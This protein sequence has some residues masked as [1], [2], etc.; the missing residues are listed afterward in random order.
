MKKIISIAVV[1][2]LMLSLIP[3]QVFAEKV[4]FEDKVQSLS[5]EFSDL[6]ITNMIY[7]DLHELSTL[8]Y[9]KEYISPIDV[10]DGKIVYEVNFDDYIDQITI[11]KVFNG[12]LILNFYEGDK[13]DEL[14]ISADGS[15]RVNGFELIYSSYADESG[16]LGSNVE[17][18]SNSIVAPQARYEHY[19][20]NPIKNKSTY[21]ISAGKYESNI[22]SW[23]VSTI[24]GMTIG[25]IATIITMSFNAPLG[26]SILVSCASSLASAML[27]RVEIYGMD[28]AYWSFKLKRYESTSSTNLDRNYMYTGNCYSKRNYKG[29][30]FPHTFYYQNYFA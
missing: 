23:G 11:E 6:E 24:V 27:T 5:R 17:A 20:K 1:L 30:A 22:I 28:D 8:G 14:I 3:M 29:T 18:S 9:S 21:T 19:S 13:H 25:A 2:S 15:M 4:T 26:L 10:I 16:L 7:E 12:D